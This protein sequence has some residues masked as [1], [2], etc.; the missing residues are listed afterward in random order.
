MERVGAAPFRRGAVAVTLPPT[1]RDVSAPY[2][3]QIAISPN[4][5]QRRTVK[6][7]CVEHSTRSGQPTF[8]TEQERASTVSWFGNPTSEV[9]ASALVDGTGLITEFVCGCAALGDAWPHRAH[10][11]PANPFVRVPLLEL[12]S[13][14]AGY[15]NRSY[16]GLEWT[17]PVQGMGFT[18]AAYLGAAWWHVYRLQKTFPTIA[19]SAA[20]LPEH[21]Q[22]DQGRAIGK[23]DLGN[24]F[25]L[26]RLL[27]EIRRWERA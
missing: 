16:A 23:S 21:R 13:W 27:E 15:L 10:A 2:G 6:T 22:T 17:Q 7:G 9:S 26:D 18:D 11:N 25:A 20:T 4:H 19:F 12:E 14:H 5:G 8:T 3:I 24:P 1:R